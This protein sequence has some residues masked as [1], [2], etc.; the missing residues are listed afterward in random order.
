MRPQSINK[1]TYSGTGKNYE[2][3]LVTYNPIFKGSINFN[4][5][6]LGTNLLNR[7]GAICERVCMAN[8]IDKYYTGMLRTIT[9]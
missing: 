1:G 3:P 7:I 4:I 6:E 8:S 9:D 5:F 2:E